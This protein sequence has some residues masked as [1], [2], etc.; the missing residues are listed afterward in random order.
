MKSRNFQEYKS[1]IIEQLAEAHECSFCG[2]VSAESNGTVM[3]TEDIS[4]LMVTLLSQDTLLPG[5]NISLRFANSIV[6]AELCSDDSCSLRIDP[7]KDDTV[8]IV[9]ATVTIVVILLVL[10]TVLSITLL[11]Q[12]STRCCW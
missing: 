1:V 10:L 5:Q 8:L 3:C 4:I 12:R 9:A 11:I 7:P 6:S 2:E